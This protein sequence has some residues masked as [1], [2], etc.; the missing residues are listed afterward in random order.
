[1]RLTALS[2]STLLLT[3]LLAPAR[4]DARCTSEIELQALGAAMHIDLSCRLDHLTAGGP[5]CSDPGFPT[6]AG[7]APTRMAEILL[8]TDQS[9]VTGWTSKEIRCQRDLALS[10]ARFIQGRLAERAEG[11][12]RAKSGRA[13]RRPARSCS[14]AKRSNNG[15]GEP[16]V[17][18]GPPCDTLLSPLGQPIDG[19]GVVGCVRASI[20]AEIDDIAPEALRPN[21]VLIV[22]DDQRYDTFDVT[23]AIASLRDESVSFNNAF[24]TNPVCTPSRA[25]ILTG[26][27]SK[28]NGI[29]TNLTFEHVED[30]VAEWLADSGYTNGLY[31]K[32]INNSELLGFA[33]PPGWHEWKSFLDPSGGE[34]YGARIN[35]N[36]EERQLG[37]S[38]YSTDWLRNAAIKF[39]KKKASGPFFLMFTPFAPHAPATAAKRHIG[40]LEGYPLHRPPTWF[41]S[42]AGKPTWVHFYKAIAPP[43]F[44]DFVDEFR[45][46]QL[47]SLLSVDQAVEKIV[48]ILEKSDLTDN[49]VVI[50]TS[51]HG[52]NWGE[53]WLLQKFNPYEES[54]RV[55]YTVRYPRRFPIPGTR[56]QMVLNIDLAPTIADLAGATAS[57]DRDGMSLAP[58]L[59]SDTAPWRDEFLIETRGEF[60]TAPSVSVRTDDYKYIDTDAGTG[61]TE[62]LYD[63]SVDPYEAT[64]VA[65][66]PSYAAVLA[67]MVARLD[68]LRP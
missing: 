40:D 32:Y 16:L 36:G 28:N 4:A 6:C 22:T 68:A 43:N 48:K 44:P 62:E 15:F 7:S 38:R 3:T 42:P 1:M 14:K 67:D 5:A 61:I 19:P 56:D 46:N 58:L 35:D 65:T 29:P 12:R 11:I 25:S 30:T 18:V 34:F 20:E 52:F 23:P 54:I 9:S 27:Y 45:H 31:G 53:H 47:E 13:L 50:F 57:P 37:T 8:G 26:L 21:I 49:T 10:A 17:R 60:I 51:D 39:I 66:E 2:A 59:A 24:V 55:P 63:L 64:N 33:P 41:G